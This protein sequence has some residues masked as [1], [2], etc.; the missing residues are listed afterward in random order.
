MSPPAKKLSPGFARDKDGI[1]IWEGR[2]ARY[3]NPGEAVKT[4]Y[5]GKL[6]LGCTEWKPTGHGGHPCGKTAR[7]D[8]DANGNATKC[9]N[10]SKAREAKKIELRKRNFQKTRAMW[11][12]IDAVQAAVQALEPALRRIA[13]GANNPRKLAEETISALD[14][15][16]LALAKIDK[17]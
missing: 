7:H 13:Q 16:R 11:A 12:A 14:D 17:S 3:E 10:H 8:P 1:L 6:R 9:G 4:W 2:G 5:A 15:A